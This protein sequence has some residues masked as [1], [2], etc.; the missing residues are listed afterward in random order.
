MEGR[1][2]LEVPTGTDALRDHRVDAGLGRLDRLLHEPTWNL[3][4]A[5]G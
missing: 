4:K 5:L 3:I 1:R 2:R